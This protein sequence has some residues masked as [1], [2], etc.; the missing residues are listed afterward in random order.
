MFKKLNV[1]SLE[2][3]PEEISRKNL[4]Q[5]FAQLDLSKDDVQIDQVSQCAFPSTCSQSVVT[6]QSHDE[7]VRRKFRSYE[8]LKKDFASINVKI[9]TDQEILGQLIEQLNKTDND[10]DRKTILTDLEYYLHQVR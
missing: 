8:E 3:M 10:E 9:Q 1:R 7:E 5:A 6:V 4:E 2:T